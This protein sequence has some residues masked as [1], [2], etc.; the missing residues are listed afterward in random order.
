MII[1]MG[2]SESDLEINQRVAELFKNHG[3]VI[4][5]SSS[6]MDLKPF[7]GDNT[8]ILLDVSGK[9]C[10]LHYGADDVARE[11][12]KQG[13]PKSVTK[14][15]L[16]VSDV[17]DHARW[18]FQRTLSKS[19]DTMADTLAWAGYQT[20]VHCLDN[21]GAYIKFLIPPDQ[22]NNEWQIYRLNSSPETSAPDLESLKRE[23]NKEKVATTL[24][25]LAYLNDPQ[26]AYITNKLE[27]NPVTALLEMNERR[28]ARQRQTSQTTTTTSEE[29]PVDSTGKEK[30]I[31][32]ANAD[33]AAPTSVP[34]PKN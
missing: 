28:A 6:L 18:G 33:A 17:P 7:E 13:L 5:Y 14:I 20:Q 1:I 16:V 23:P 34:S 2:S 24:D 21:G 22:N 15:L 8:L 26:K 10:I 19:A 27:F 11:L 12:I 4:Q 29:L 9:T 31:P 3:P 32:K 30:E 25:I